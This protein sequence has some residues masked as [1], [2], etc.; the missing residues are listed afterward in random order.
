[1]SGGRGPG[2]R[3]IAVVAKVA[4]REAAHTAQELAEWLRRRDIEVVL[5]EA[6]LRTQGINGA[7]PFRPE[8]PYDLVIALG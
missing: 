3:R 8:E 1:M 5:D 4:S 7:L 6:T 2:L